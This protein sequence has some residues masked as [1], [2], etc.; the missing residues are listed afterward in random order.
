[1]SFLELAKKRFSVRHY[2]DR[3]VEGEKLEYVL[4]AGRIAPSAVNYQ[5]WYFI[6][7]RDEELRKQIASTYRGEWILEAPVIIAV[8]GDHSKSWR[9]ADGKDHC[10]LDAAIAIDHM[11]LAA[12]E[13]GLGTCW[14]CN[15]NAMQCHRILKLPG[16]VEIVALLPLGYPAENADLDRH[17]TKRKKM[18][19][20]VCWDGFDRRK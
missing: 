12:A 15:F 11:T 19:E 3:G 1:M 13:I 18:E 16:H 6:V 8:C 17:T 7:A 4:E 10:N 14:I 2:R 20:V 9:R 5:P